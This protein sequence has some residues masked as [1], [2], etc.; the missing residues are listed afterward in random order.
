MREGTVGPYMAP[1][2]CGE[3]NSN[4]HLLFQC[5][6]LRSKLI[7]FPFIFGF[8]SSPNIYTNNN[9][10]TRFTPLTFDQPVSFGLFSIHA[11]C[12]SYTTSKYN[13]SLILDRK[14]HTD[15]EKC[16]GSRMLCSDSMTL[17]CEI[18]DPLNAR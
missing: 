4:S 1:G 11:V 2:Y 8:L 15:I 12:Y 18:Y 10:R 6:T 14:A 13:I 3:Q 17:E 9:T 5:L 7:H 16:Y